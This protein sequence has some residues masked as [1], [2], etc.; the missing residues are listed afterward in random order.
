MNI[1]ARAKKLDPG[2][3]IE[4]GVLRRLVGH[5]IHDDTGKIVG[6]VNRAWVE[7]GYIMYDAII[8]DPATQKKLQTDTQPS[9]GLKVDL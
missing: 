2:T 1:T 9:W 6:S 4:P 5:A 8:T 3:A 7:D